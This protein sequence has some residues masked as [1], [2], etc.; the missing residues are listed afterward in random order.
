MELTLR[1]RFG[2]L[3]QSSFEIALGVLVLSLLA[4][5]WSRSLWTAHQAICPKGSQHI[6]CGVGLYKYQYLAGG[7][8]L[9]ATI[10]EIYLRHWHLRREAAKREAAT[11]AAEAVAGND[12]D[13]VAAASMGKAVASGALRMGEGVAQVGESVCLSG[14][15]TLD[16]I[17]GLGEGVVTSSLQI[18]LLH[19]CI[20]LFA[21]WEL[22]WPYSKPAVMGQLQKEKANL[23]MVLALLL[24]AEV[25]IDLL[26]CC[27]CCRRVQAKKPDD[28]VLRL[29]L[30]P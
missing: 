4:F 9:V 15:I 14:V 17:V 11:A 3:A 6:C 5:S 22:V 12:E 20:V 28:E 13:A 2:N 23:M 26:A 30:L 1:Q 27:C 25:T 18:F 16:G 21:A 8:A 29:P 7:V 19:T 10:G 24:I